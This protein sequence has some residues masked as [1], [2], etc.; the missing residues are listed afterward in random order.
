HNEQMSLIIENM[1]DNHA[2]ISPHD[3]ILFSFQCSPHRISDESEGTAGSSVS[4]AI[5]STKSGA[6]T[7]IVPKTTDTIIS[8]LGRDIERGLK[9]NSIIYSARERG[10]IHKCG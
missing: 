6:K 4:L 3:F 9:H 2:K 5:F 8:A 7:A 1:N 10:N